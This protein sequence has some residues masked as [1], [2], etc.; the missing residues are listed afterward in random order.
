MLLAARS[1]FV[2][3]A[4]EPAA[5][6]PGFDVRKAL[7]TVPAEGRRAPIDYHVE[8]E[9]D[10]VDWAGAP[11][12]CLAEVESTFGRPV[13]RYRAGPLASVE[14]EAASLAGARPLVVL[15]KSWEP[16]MGELEDYL[17]RSRGLV[18]P[19]DWD[20]HARALQPTK[21]VHLQEWRRFCGALPDWHVLQ[22]EELR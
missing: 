7:N 11:D 3:Q 18:L 21:P 6:A 12:F 15:V 1:H 17:R 19:L 9:Y 4:R 20:E 14:E 10:L 22:I 5:P 16:P 8:A 2:N 13:T